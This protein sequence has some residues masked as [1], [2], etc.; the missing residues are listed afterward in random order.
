MNAGVSCQEPERQERNKR[1]GSWAWLSPLSGLL[2]LVAL[3][4]PLFAHGCHA[5]D[6]D[7][8]P[9]FAPQQH[10]AERSR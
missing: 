10:D 3:A 9:V 6:H 7:D 5:G 2:A 4:V 1:P 8:E